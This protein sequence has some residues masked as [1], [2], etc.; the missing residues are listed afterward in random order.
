MHICT[1][2]ANITWPHIWMGSYGKV[3]SI[4]LAW[5]PIMAITTHNLLKRTKWKLIG[6]LEVKCLR[7]VWVAYD[8]GSFLQVKLSSAGYGYI[9]IGSMLI[10]YF[11][12]RYHGITVWTLH[13]IYTRMHFHGIVSSTNRAFTETPDIVN[14]SV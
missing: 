11:C 2:Y 12:A 4:R 14:G 10:L 1:T 5:H 13:F 8:V 3:S 7:W 6:M 9:V